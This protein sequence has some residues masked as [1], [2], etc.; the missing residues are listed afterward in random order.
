MR[1]IL[2]VVLGA[3]VLLGLASFAQAHASDVNQ[4]NAPMCGS[5]DWERIKTPATEFAVSDSAA[6]C[7][8]S[9]KYEPDFAVSSVIR[10][11]QWQ[12]PNLASGYVPTGESTC[13]SSK[14]TCFR[15]PVEAENDGAPEA[16]VGTWISGGYQGNEAFDI[17]FSPNA[18]R[19]SAATR[20]GDTELMIWTAYPGINDT[21]KFV[22]YATI[23]GKRFGI[24]SW[25]TG[26]GTWRY[27]A[28]LWLN[29]PNGSQGRQVNVSG[30]W[31]NPFFRNA[32]SHGWLKPTEWLWAIDFG[33]E[34]N[35]NGKDNNVHAYSLTGVN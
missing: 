25:V 17:W 27:V 9:E 18:S 21:S 12:Y 30:L 28:Y 22:A 33:F 14:D 16:S 5:N 4:Y 1:K 13:A 3:L 10:N 6:T 19:H 29:A 8:D 24:M 11:Q 34:M 26:G 32:E 35:R 2:A 20:A 7:V 15:Y 31:L 23:D